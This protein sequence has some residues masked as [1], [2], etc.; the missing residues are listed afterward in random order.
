[1]LLNCGVGEDSWESLGLQVDPVNPKGNQ[2][3]I[4][5]GRADFEAE[6]PI[7]WPPAAKNWHLKRLRCWERLRVGDGDHRGSDGWMA[8][9]TQRTW[10]WVNC[11]SWRW[12]GKPVMLQSMGLQSRTW[13]SDWSELNWI[14]FASVLLK[15][16]AYWPLIFY[17]LCGIFLCLVL[18]SGRWQPHRM[19]LE[20]FLPL[21]YFG[22]LLEV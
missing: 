7:L 12:T 16:C 3:W 14:L 5:I 8:S 22:I 13:L 21:K 20:V 6:F 15:I 18:V 17:F 4:F 10:V 2:S 9:P 19:N 11:R 1:M